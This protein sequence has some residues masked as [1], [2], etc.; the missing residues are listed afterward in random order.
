MSA[1]VEKRLAVTETQQSLVAWRLPASL[2]AVRVL[3]ASEVFT[4]M[5]I[6]FVPSWGAILGLIV[7]VVFTAALLIALARG[8]KVP[9]PCFGV[10]TSEISMMLV[11]RNA[12][13]LAGCVVGQYAENGAGFF[14]RFFV[15]ACTVAI[16]LRNRWN[17]RVG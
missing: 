1:A 17:L 11:V 2:N 7:M 14:L 13:L 6:L 4:A 3:Y 5:A 12:L 10:N 15:F 8:Q 16:L 9:C